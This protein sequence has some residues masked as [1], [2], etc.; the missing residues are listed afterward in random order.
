MI[1]DTNQQPDGRDTQGKV[2]RKGLELPCFKSTT[3]PAP[4]SVHKPGSSLNPVLGDVM[5]AS[6]HRHG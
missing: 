4:P 2:W 1:K 6:L 5:E 3:F